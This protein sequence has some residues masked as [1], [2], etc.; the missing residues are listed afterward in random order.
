MGGGGSDFAAAM[1]SMGRPR[2]RDTLAW[3]AAA[4]LAGVDLSS[5]GVMALTARLQKLRARRPDVNAWVIVETCR[6]CATHCTTF[7]HDERAY[8][9]RFRELKDTIQE[10]FPEEVRVELLVPRRGAQEGSGAATA[11]EPPVRI[12]AF[13]VFLCCPRPFAP[14]GSVKL[15]GEEFSVI[16]V[17]SKLR[18]LVWPSYDRVLRS[19]AV[20]M[21][22]V[23]LL[24]AV[25]TAARLPVGGVHLEITLGGDS[26]D[27]AAAAGEEASPRDEPALGVRIAGET[28]A[29]GVCTLLVPVNLKLRIKAWHD[30]LMTPQERIL[31]ISQSSASESFV[32]DTVL[33]L[34]Q[35][36]E[37]KELIVYCSSPRG[38]L[39]PTNVEGCQP[40]HGHVELASQKRLRVDRD[41]VLRG[42]PTL[43]RDLA[44]VA[45][46]GWCSAP[47]F[48]QARNPLA[49]GELREAARLPCPTVEVAM[50]A[51]CC[52]T[53]L[54]GVKVSID[55]EEVES[56]TGANGEAVACKVLH[57]EHTLR[58]WQSAL[59]AEIL[60]PTPFMIGGASLYHVHMHMSPRRLRFVCNTSSGPTSSGGACFADLWL[61]AGG[62]DD[63]SVEDIILPSGGDEVWP[64]DGELEG[65]GPPLVVRDGALTSAVAA[66]E[67]GVCGLSR[68]LASVRSTQ[69]RWQVSLLPL[70]GPAFC[71]MSQLAATASL[72]GAPPALWL[73]Q[74]AA[75]EFEVPKK[76]RRPA[77]RSLVLRSACCGEGFTCA[78][79]LLLGAGGAAAQV[80]QQGIFD[81]QPEGIQDTTQETED[82]S[83]AVRITGVPSCLLPGGT[84]EYSVPLPANGNKL[85]LELGITCRIYLY[86]VPPEEDF[87]ED[88]MD[89][90][91]PEVGF[92]SI[93]V[94][95]DHLPEEALPV[96]GTLVCST[97]QG[98]SLALEGNSVGP[99]L[100][101]GDSPHPP[102]LLGNMAFRLDAPDGF[103][104]SE[105]LP[106]PLTE[107]CADLGGC[108]LQR[109]MACPVAIGSFKTLPWPKPARFFVRSSIS[110]HGYSNVSITVCGR[111]AQPDDEPGYFRVPRRR[112]GDRQ[113]K[114]E[115]SFGDSLPAC[116]APGG[117][118]TFEVPYGPDEPECVELGISCLV[119]VYWLP[120]KDDDDAPIE[121]CSAGDDVVEGLVYV[122]ARADQV[123]AEALPVDGVL[124]FAGSA[125][126]IVLDGSSAGPYLL[127]AS[128][129]DGDE[130]SADSPSP[131]A[132]LRLE[133]CT[134]DGFE[135]CD[136][137]PSPFLERSSELDSCE[138]SRL[139]ECPVAIGKFRSLPAPPLRVA[140]R[141]ACCG[142]S[143]EGAEVEVAGGKPALVGDG[144]VMRRR[145]KGG[146]VRVC[147]RGVPPSLLS[148]GCAGD[149]P[150]ERVASYGPIQPEEVT[151]EALCLLWVY[152]LP[153]EEP[154]DEFE[155]DD[156]PGMLMVAVDE[157]QVPE[158]A[159]PVAGT[160]E[161]PGTTVPRVTLDGSSM[162][163]F[164]LR[165]SA[166]NAACI[167]SRLVFDVRP[168]SFFN[169]KPR[170]PMP[171]TQRHED[172]GGCELQRLVQCPVAVGNFEP[173]PPPG[174]RQLELRT[175][176]CGRCF[177]GSQVEVDG[178]AA[179]PFDDDGIIK[180]CRRRRSDRSG[181]MQ[182][183]ISGVQA[184]LLPDGATACTIPYGEEV[185]ATRSFDVSAVVWVYWVP[186]GEDED[187][188]GEADAEECEAVSTG[189]V[190]VAADPDQVP[191]EAL[192]LR[193][194]LHCPGAA[195]AAIHLDG[196]CIGPFLL[197][198]PLEADAAGA[199][200]GE[201][202][203]VLSGLVLEI[204]PPEGFRYQAREPSPFVEHAIELGGCELQR[205]VHCPKAVG[206]LEPLPLPPLE[207]ALRT[208]CCRRAFGGATVQVGCQPPALMSDDGLIKVRRRRGGGSCKLQFGGVPVHLLPGCQECQ[209]VP[210]TN[211]DEL[212]EVDVRCVVWVYWLPLDVDEDDEDAEDAEEPP[213]PKEGML[214]VV[215]DGEQV[216]EEAK[217]VA[218]ALE[219]SSSSGCRVELDGQSI[220]PYFIRSTSSQES[221][222]A[223]G[224][225]KFLIDAPDG[226]EYN[227]RDPTA[228]FERCEE[229]GGCELERLVT[230][231]ICVG[232]LRERQ[233]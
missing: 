212:L 214:F 42:A 40:F 61:V 164:A 172:L 16:S 23:P 199:E 130:G 154:D 140:L 211:A 105:K 225:V 193:G 45:K 67:G 166:V 116:M 184:H 88:A 9:R 198:R 15:P 6:D 57:G 70:G 81:L 143:F 110:S 221:S 53:R 4:R 80:D 189:T 233:T 204:T 223:L 134:P 144:L 49:R 168:P 52:G 96:S 201:E 112:R 107:R 113:G 95:R 63:E 230:C 127:A 147:F 138:L 183:Q 135:Y 55:G 74:L 12:G 149:S 111:P 48:P 7:R 66:L 216:P 152:W 108:E 176:C 44:F 69:R 46:E 104:Y 181:S 28:D 31:H 161:C 232:S 60:G 109:L 151:F 51:G 77:R 155:D 24:L 78:Q 190:W 115:V 141:T 174:P 114:L 196:S 185:P 89:D 137:S 76:K 125:D 10:H 129:N 178:A 182:I 87:S 218:G 3:E 34:W 35:R 126:D 206:Q 20:A 153:P 62:A 162:G 180:L 131:L 50:L 163:P 5:E 65:C 188:D 73:A 215:A 68:A 33:Q 38:S 91:A 200:S 13:E 191:E 167:L 102:C 124:R 226:W 121:G 92:V 79:V 120:P 71:V 83:I 175:R 25:G 72:P 99:F 106:S 43:L 100:L 29:N 148:G 123:P 2:N 150:H 93:A 103:E 19:L 86:W 203:C 195:V 133:P 173:L 98:G 170:I 82:G 231:P 85:R 30:P 158:E 14:F 37:G 39:Q 8:V 1:L 169:Y 17:F 97:L 59:S 117:R 132:A 205:L 94:N 179:R 202:A 222:C 139:M 47:P 122:A 219:W 192:P 58:S 142:S 159:Q 209:V 213:A 101:Q 18:T 227:P 22:R 41:G 186:P 21:P 217:P 229:L 157:S 165:S 27:A 187:D 207:L 228:L 194:T 160:L 197:N 128:S 119:W 145:R 220:G 224:D 26:G 156:L 171:L 56:V 136:Y 75:S 11:L 36:V 208:S 118:A 64:F 84:A 146:Q 177:A 90:D 32:V 210:Y 54:P